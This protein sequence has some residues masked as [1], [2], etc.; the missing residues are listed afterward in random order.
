MSTV[1]ER[2]LGLLAQQSF[3]RRGDYPSLLYEGHWHSS[4]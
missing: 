3:E 2:H 4:G 1:G